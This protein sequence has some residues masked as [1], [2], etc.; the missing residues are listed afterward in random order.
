MTERSERATYFRFWFPGKVSDYS[1]NLPTDPYVRLA[2]IRFLGVACFHTSRLQPTPQSASHLS[3]RFPNTVNILVVPSWLEI[4]LKLARSWD[5][6]T[7]VS[8]LTSQRPANS[9]CGRHDGSTSIARHATPC[10]ISDPSIG[11]YS[12]RHNT[13]SDHAAL[14][15]GCDNVLQSD[16]AGFPGT[17]TR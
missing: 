9:F 15:T 14:H 8:P 13:G 1:T 17:M 16:D 12:G 11:C 6:V 10:S 5:V 4:I 7:R 3:A 2:L